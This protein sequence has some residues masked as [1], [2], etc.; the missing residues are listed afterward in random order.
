[1]AYR[2]K[3]RRSASFAVQIRLAVV[4]CKSQRLSVRLA[5]TF[6]SAG[7]GM[8]MMLAFIQATASHRALEQPFQYAFAMRGCTQEDAPA[9]EIY[10]TETPFAGLGDPSRPYIRFEVITSRSEAIASVTITLIQMRRDPTVPG[11]IARAELVQQGQGP[12]WLS[13]TIAVR[14]AAPGRRV[15]GHYDVTTPT[16]KRFNNSFIAEYS[17]R[18][19][20]C[21]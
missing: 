5:R 12:I 3:P 13:G 17:N 20:V 7:F 1:M 14:E 19:A 18:T 16:G 9:L 21:G 6:L 8:I 11:P 4:S 10:L 15:S 2:M